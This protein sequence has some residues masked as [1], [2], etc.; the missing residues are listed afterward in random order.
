[1]LARVQYKHIIMLHEV[2]DGPTHGYIYMV[3]ELMPLGPVMNL[4][5][6]HQ[7]G[8]AADHKLEDVLSC[9]YF[10]QLLLA[11][12]YIH[13][14]GIIHRD[15]KPSNILLYSKDTVKLADFGVAHICTDL[16][17]DTL[18]DSVGTPSFMAP[19]MVSADSPIFRGKK[20]DVW[21]MGVTL[22]CF[23][24]GQLP[25]VVD[26]PG[27]ELHA[28]IRDPAKPELGRGLEKPL[29]R[30]VVDLMTQIFTKNPEARGVLAAL[31]THSWVTRYNTAPLEPPPV[32]E[33]SEAA[34]VPTAALRPAPQRFRRRETAP[35]PGSP[36]AN[37]HPAVPI[38]S[39]AT[40]APLLLLQLPATTHTVQPNELE[41]EADL[42]TIL[43]PVSTAPSINSHT[44]TTQLETTVDPSG[45]T[46]RSLA[47][48]IFAPIVM[49]A[50]IPRRTTPSRR[51]RGQVWRG[52]GLDKDGAQTT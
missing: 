50:N 28:E 32:I 42:E 36:L 4:E 1:V 41:T 26:Y 35:T 33:V 43:S 40:R 7:G 49:Q 52:A 34:V 31:R 27:L 14:H 24:H 22:Y 3:F 45:P 47:Q 8:N 23:L 17:D 10:R 38:P 44:S 15:I 48:T 46:T 2:I 5:T 12:E 29:S 21:A 9:T 39:G 11:V 16:D 30:Q 18:S 19:E 51:K 6:R 13:H 37:G 25:W 20:A